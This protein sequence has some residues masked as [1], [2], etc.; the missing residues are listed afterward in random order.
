MFSGSPPAIGP[1]FQFLSLYTSKTNKKTANLL[2]CLSWSVNVPWAKV[3]L[4][5]KLSSLN[6]CLLLDCGLEFPSSSKSRTGNSWLTLNNTFKQIFKSTFY[7]FFP[8]V[9]GRLSKLPHL[10]FLEVEVFPPY[11]TALYSMALW[12]LTYMYSTICI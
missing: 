6:F 5:T 11:N 4:N 8:V 12:C 2:S 1:R 10:S 9:G 7:L 3:A